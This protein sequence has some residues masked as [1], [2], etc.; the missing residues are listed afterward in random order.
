MAGI[1]F[2]CNRSATA[3]GLSDISQKSQILRLCRQFR[4]RP[5]RNI[6]LYAEDISTLQQPTIRGKYSRRSP[7]AKASPPA[8]E[9]AYQPAMRQQRGLQTLAA[10]MAISAARIHRHPSSIYL[11]PAIKTRNPFPFSHDWLTRPAWIFPCPLA[12][13]LQTHKK[14]RC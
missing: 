11:F 7:C 5:C 14:P 1:S 9:Q 3:K 2:I 8:A 6:S 12:A 13:L 4:T 10:R